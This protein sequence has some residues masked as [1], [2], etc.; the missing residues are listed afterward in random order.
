MSGILIGVKWRR[1][2]CEEIKERSNR[3][4]VDGIAFKNIK[5]K[6]TYLKL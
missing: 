2:K 5:I 3:T 6:F 1:H 4:Q